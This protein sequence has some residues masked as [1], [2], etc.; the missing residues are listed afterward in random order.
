MPGCAKCRHAAHGCA[1]CNP[2]RFSFRSRCT[3]KARYASECAKAFRTWLVSTQGL[4]DGTARDYA[5]A[6]KGLLQNKGAEAKGTAKM[7]SV[8][9]TARSHI[10]MFVRL[11]QFLWAGEGKDKDKDKDKDKGKAKDKVPIVSCGVPGS[12]KPKVI[13]VAVKSSKAGVFAKRLRAVGRPM[14]LR[15]RP[16]PG[17]Q[18]ALECV[19]EESQVMSSKSSNVKALLTTG[20][21]VRKKVLKPQLKLKRADSSSGNGSVAANTAKGARHT[22]ALAHDAG[23]VSKKVLK[24]RMKLKRA[25]SFDPLELFNE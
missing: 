17:A 1:A 10:E 21:A 15:A 11:P 24:P 9:N 2:Q 6:F 8:T 13:G 25:V 4:T 20:G 12:S 19:A 22:V 16:A 23:P 5:W 7:Q 14:S 3:R 18:P